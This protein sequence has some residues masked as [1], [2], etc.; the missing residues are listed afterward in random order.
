MAVPTVDKDQHSGKIIIECNAARSH[1]VSIKKNKKSTSKRT[2]IRASNHAI[3]R[4]RRG[5][6]VDR[7]ANGGI[8]GNDAKVIFRR[9]KRVDVTGIDNHELSSLPMVDATAKTLTDKGEV[10]LI[11]RNYAYHGV[12]RTIHSSGQIDW[13]KNKVHDGSLKAGGRQVI[14]T[15]DG[16]YIPINII[17]G[18]PY[19]HMEPN[20]AEEFERLP[21]IVLTQGGEWDPSVLD[22][23][24]T[25]NENWVDE[26]KREDDP[27]Y[28]SP[29]DSRG[30]YK[31]K[32]P[33][34]V[35]KTIE[36]PVEVPN[37]EPKDVTDV[38][39]NFHRIDPGLEIHEAFH[40]ACTL[41]KVYVYEG[42]GMPD[43]QEDDLQDVPEDEKEPGI[44]ATPPVESKPRPI[45]YSK[46]RAQ[47][48]HVP[49]EKIRKT[50]QS[51][52]QNAVTV[53]SGAKIQQTFKSPNP[54]L[55]IPRRH[56]AV[57][58]DSIFADVP[59]VDTPGHTSA[60]IFVGRSSLVLDPY[61]MV[62]P[63]EFVNTFLDSIRE[64]GA[65]DKLISDHA[66]YEMSARVKDIM[67]AL[68]IGHWKSEPYY[69]HQ[70]FA[71]HRW[72][73]A[74]AN[75]EWLMA[76]LDVDPDCW[77]LALKYV[78][79]VMNLTA[80]RILG[81]R[82]PLE[83]LTGQTQDISILLYFMFWD[84][85]YCARHANKQPGSQKGQEMRGRFVG[86]AHDV[87]HALT[88]L[89][90][91][92]DTRKVVK[93]SK[94]RLAECPENEIRMDENNL[95]LDRAAGQTIKRKIHFRTAGRDPC[96]SKDF[97]MKTLAPDTDKMN[98]VTPPFEDQEDD[99]SVDTEIIEPEP[100]DDV[101]ELPENMDEEM[102]NPLPKSEADDFLK[103][104]RGRRGKKDQFQGSRRQGAK[105]PTPGTRRS[106]R[107]RSRAN[108]MSVLDPVKAKLDGKIEKRRRS[109]S[110][111]DK[112]D[113]KERPI[114]EE[115]GEWTYMSPMNNKPLKDEDEKLWSDEE[116]SQLA[117]HLK[118]R[119][120]GEKNPLQE[121]LKFAKKALAIS[122]PY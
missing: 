46:Y 5:A 79:D 57:A 101:P 85:V 74:K 89:V 56:E 49:V 99:S 11:L 77:L 67:R 4:S 88:F 35:G 9:A 83:V 81:W 92:D 76:F 109:R 18:L 73:H 17:R 112:A 94:L 26:V 8:L 34:E 20:T 50:F 114:T 102:V 119:K 96:L 113:E 15:Q 29:F 71:E 104:N 23:I 106:D 68:M 53:M 16:Y 58:T 36:S 64:R 55:N 27:V 48:L 84:I 82:P 110:P 111:S 103:S 33:P 97:I 108:M 51:T 69:Q 39:V 43:D 122:Q 80:E 60:Q 115:E 22:Y 105:S 1:S 32:T 25:D 30:E 31:H 7:G 2:K 117:E 93:R 87:G 107:L 120:P 66:N 3:K 41:N 86:F 12:N 24:L 14:I 45:D 95:R 72:G 10:I 90:L 19:I 121:P 116:K 13:Y 21:H 40:D 98:D 54:A 61:G 63:K 38:E 62:S 47:F 44:E 100:I 37:E 70:N 118:N 59:A 42:E 52:T 78:C 75:L 91:T 65:M 6:L 28:D